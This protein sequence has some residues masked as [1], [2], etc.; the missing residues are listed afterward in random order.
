M[1]PAKS[2]NDHPKRAST[3][4]ELQ[5][6]VVFHRSGDLDRAAALYQRVLDRTPGNA[7]ALHML[8]L[9]AGA[10]GQSE[11]AIDLIVKALKA[12]RPAPRYHG[13]LLAGPLL[14]LRRVLSDRMMDWLILSAFR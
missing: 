5:A 10:R 1:T 14:F 13:G 9:V 3:E 7:D 12:K 4:Q 11:R 2:L 8:G 6:A